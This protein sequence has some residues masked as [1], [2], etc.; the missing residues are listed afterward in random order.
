MTTVQ[1]FSKVIG[2]DSNLLKTQRLII[3]SGKNVGIIYIKDLVDYPLVETE[4]QC[5]SIRGLSE[6]E[7]RELQGAIDSSD[8]IISESGI[9][10]NGTLQLQADYLQH[11]I[12]QTR[13]WISELN[14]K[15]RIY[16]ASMMDSGFRTSKKQDY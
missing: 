2:D 3:K 11:T 12:D 15:G 7:N 8:S 4:L 9:G 14:V 13:Q 5:Q 1:F 16:R 10:N 6:N